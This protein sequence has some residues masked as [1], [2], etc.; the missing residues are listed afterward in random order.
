MSTIR[1]TILTTLFLLLGKV[2]SSPSANEAL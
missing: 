1:I 2:A